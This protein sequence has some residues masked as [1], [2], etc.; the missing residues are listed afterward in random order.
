M[1]VAICDD[2]SIFR[3][4]LKLILIEYKQK[5]RLQMDIVEFCNGNDLLNSNLTFDI[6][7]LD[8]QMPGDN[9]LNIAK[10]LRLRHNICSIIFITSFPE[11][12]I[13]A[14]SVNTF[15]FL[16]KPLDK[17]K[18]ISAVDDY[19]REK[20]MFSPIVIN[21]YDGQAII[22]SEDIVYLE[23]DGKY[24]N[25]RTINGFYHS[26]KTLS[27]VFKLLPQHCFF[28]THKSYVV[29]LYCISLINGNHI[30][31]SNNE[32]VVISRNNIVEFK[33][34]YGEFINHFR[35]RN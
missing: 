24:C 30:T 33:K 31:L 4:D 19:I 17:N 10:A 21:T 25:I 29:N 23:G 32:K 8:Y 22:N 20:K 6:V 15:R 7:F 5:M 1:I 9:G 18:L 27:G 35:T 28:R 16:I 3:K 26:S 2:E 13:D 11:F 34:A 14:F 12:M